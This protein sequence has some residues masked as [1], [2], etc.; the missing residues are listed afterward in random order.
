MAVGLQAA[1]QEVKS[2]PPPPVTWSDPFLPFFSF[3]AIIPN[4]NHLSIH[5]ESSLKKISKSFVLYIYISILFSVQH[6]LANFF[7]PRKNVTNERFPPG[8]WGLRDSSTG[9][10][11]WS[12]S[13]L[14]WLDCSAWP[15]PTC[16]AV[17]LQNS[18]RTVALAPKKDLL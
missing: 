1:F 12:P 8:A 2:L 15:E 7:S 9:F 11:L 4:F 6:S 10:Q 17:K 5:N 16:V 14:A 18:S 3:S 13:S